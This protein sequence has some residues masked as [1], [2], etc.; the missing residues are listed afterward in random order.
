[1]EV[2]PG[3][4]GDA[5]HPPAR[6]ADLA[7]LQLDNPVDVTPFPL[8]STARMSAATRVIGWG[9]D[10]DDQRPVPP[11]G[12]PPKGLPPM[13]EAAHEID[14]VTTF[15]SLCAAIWITDGELCVAFDQQ[16]TCAGDSGSPV[17]QKVDGR[18]Q[19]VGLVSH[20]Y[21]LL[22]R[23][24]KAFPGD[25]VTDL[26]NPEYRDWIMRIAC[27]RTLSDPAP[28]GSPG[29]GPQDTSRGTR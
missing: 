18:W 25:A 3:W 9:I 19:L 2:F 8:A 20:A 1:V 17:L 11:K 21:G 5:L 7:L 14:G 6:H 24:E 29:A 22:P 16:A 13:A 15:P 27:A 26:T 4:D 10:V 12:L 28:C 23:C